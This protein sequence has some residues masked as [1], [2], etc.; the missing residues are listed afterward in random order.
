MCAHG[1]GSPHSAGVSGRRIANLRILSQDP[2]AFE[3]PEFSNSKTYI[4]FTLP[5]ARS[6]IINKNI[7]DKR[8]V[9]SRHTCTFRQR[10]EKEIRTKEKTRSVI[11]PK[12]GVIY[13]KL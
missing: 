3:S 9:A 6:E 5:R 2:V 1:R 13:R 7:T 8:L 12:K 10:E 11:I 4:Y